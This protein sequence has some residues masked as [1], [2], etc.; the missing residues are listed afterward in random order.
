MG[1]PVLEKIAAELHAIKQGLVCLCSANL[2]VA[3]I[4]SAE[5]DYDR[6][7]AIKEANEVL[8]T[9]KKSLS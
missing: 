8:K 4:Q 6:N 9:M 3:R 5:T 1:T 2:I 7:E